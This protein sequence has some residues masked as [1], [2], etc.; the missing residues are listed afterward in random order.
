MK[1]INFDIIHHLSRG[2]PL[3]KSYNEHFAVKSK[4]FTKSPGQDK[5][6]CDWWGAEKSEQ[7]KA[8]YLYPKTGCFRSF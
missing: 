4:D 3:E 2:D 8:T 6:K 5:K 7:R 1:V